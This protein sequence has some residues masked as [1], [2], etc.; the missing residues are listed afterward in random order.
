MPGAGGDPGGR[1]RGLPSSWAGGHR[2]GSAA[3][4]VQQGQGPGSRGPWESTPSQGPAQ[5]LSCREWPHLA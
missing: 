3:S 2:A 5:H 4:A 1:L